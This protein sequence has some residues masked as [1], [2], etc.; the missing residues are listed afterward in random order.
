MS[1]AR[2][3]PVTLLPSPIFRGFLLDS[4]SR[5]PSRRKSLCSRA[6]QADRASIDKTSVFFLI[7]AAS[8]MHTVPFHLT[9][10]PYIFP[11]LITRERKISQTAVKRDITLPTKVHIVKIMVFQVIIYG[12]KSWMIK[13]AE[14]QRTDA[15]ELC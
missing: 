14:C 7:I 3:G 2:P 1:P 8:K 4:G 11:A 13:K 10:P 6:R 15:F 5:E 12:C 9:S